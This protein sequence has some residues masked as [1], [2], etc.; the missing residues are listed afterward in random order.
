M[1]TEPRRFTVCCSALAVAIVVALAATGASA[2]S[3]IPGVQTQ[4]VSNRGLAEVSGKGIPVNLPKVANQNGSS[5]VLWDELQGKGG[6]STNIQIGSAN[7]QNTS[8]A[9]GR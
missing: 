1:S 4:T 7:L 2:A 8:M 9:V 6:K 3:L 5:V